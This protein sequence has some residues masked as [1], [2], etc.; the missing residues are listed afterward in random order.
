M[1][2]RTTNFHHKKRYTMNYIFLSTGF[3]EIEALATV[4]ILRR[5]ALPVCMVSVETETTVVGSHG[6]PVVADAQ[7]AACNFADADMLILPG[8]SIRLMEFPALGELLRQHH[9]AHKPLAAIC[10]APSVLGVLG[11]LQGERATCYPGF[12]HYLGASHVGGRVVVSNHIITANGPGT[13]IDFALQIVAS[14]CGEA[15]A[16]NVRQ[17]MLLV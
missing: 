11:I 10:A 4:D 16:N 15:C 17:A 5:A 1:C 6:I 12:E 7:F 2:F 3:E 9:A 14:L 8:G 13:A